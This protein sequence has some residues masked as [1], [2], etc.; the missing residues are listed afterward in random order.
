MTDTSS[1]TINDVHHQD[2]SPCQEN[3]RTRDEM[4]IANCYRQILAYIGED[5][6]RDSL[7]KTPERAAMCLLTMTK[8]YEGNKA[9]VVS[10]SILKVNDA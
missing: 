8:G 2:G 9:G 10:S 3:D 4:K 6:T 7:L 1:R 5:P